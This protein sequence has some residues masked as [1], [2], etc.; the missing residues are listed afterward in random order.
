MGKRDLVLSSRRAWGPTPAPTSGTASHAFSTPSSRMNR[1]TT[2]A[3]PQNAQDQSVARPPA[4]LSCP[5]SRRLPRHGSIRS[6]ASLL[7]SPESRSSEGA[8]RGRHPCH[9]R[10]VGR[11]KMG[12]DKPNGFLQE[13][14]DND[15]QVEYRASL[16][17]LDRHMN[18]R[19]DDT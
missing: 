13:N 16:Y 5:P 12:T 17:S 1:P 2:S 14:C 3:T 10:P 8:A 15:G 19:Y 9:H 18:I 11:P 6:S 7:N 4:A